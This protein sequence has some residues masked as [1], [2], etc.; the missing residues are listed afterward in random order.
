MSLK[1]KEIK[2]TY[3][4]LEDFLSYAK[5]I[6]PII[7][8]RMINSKTGIILRHDVDF[9]IYQAYKLSKI[10]KR[11]GITSTFFIMTTCHTYNP[12]SPLNRKLLSEMIKD[13]FEIGL[14]FDPT[15]YGNISFDDLR[16]KVKIECQILES[17]ITEP[18]T[19]I[20][21]H[22]PSLSGKYP[23]FEG[24]INAYSEDIFSDEC[25]LSDSCMDFRGKT[26]YE[27]VNKAGNMSL[28]IVLHPLHWSEKGDNYIEIFYKYIYR[29]V[30]SI[31]ENFRLNPTYKLCIGNNKLRNILIREENYNDKKKD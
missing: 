10:E 5:K 29:L 12:L 1:N 22:N 4:E 17:V 8:L 9:D 19:S 30:D 14:H 26:P 3:K 21:L 23:I 11:L 16:D 7:P 24:Y 27:F 6:A 13:G 20:S 28:Q 25:Y 15:V 31:D 18:I 2:F